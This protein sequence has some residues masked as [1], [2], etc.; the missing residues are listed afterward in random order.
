LA[1]RVFEIAKEL[2]VKSKAVVEKCHAEG[3]P[4]TIIKNHMSTVSAGLEATIREWFAAS[5]DGEEHTAI[6]TGE[7]VDLKQARA[8]PKKAKA[9]SSDGDEGADGD[10]ETGGGTAT[11]TEPPAPSATP[12]A[13]PAP[14]AG[15][16]D[17]PPAASER[18]AP[19]AAAPARAPT[20][21]PAPAATPVGPAVRAEAPAVSDESS[22]ADNAAPKAQQNVPERPKDVT[23]AGPQ[24]EKKAPVRLSGPKVVRVEAPDRIEP[25]RPR[26]TGP[27]DGGMGFGGPGPM[28]A[29]VDD[30]GRSP[31]R[32]GPGGG[33]RRDAGSGGGGERRRGRTDTGVGTSSNAGFSEQDLAEREMRLQ[34]SGGYLK[35]R[36]QQLRRQGGTG[37]RA[38]TPAQKG[39]KVTIAEPF[40]IKDLSA[41]TGV[42]G[43]DIVKKLFMQGV[44]ATIN[45]GIETEKAQ[46][47]MI[48]YDIE[49]EVVEAKSAEQKVSESFAEREM[50]N[51]Q[52]RGPS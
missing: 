19:A 10:A 51:E 29:P 18:A 24:L 31:R 44:M 16:S 25:P 27:R 4:D 7:K 21:A 33:R 28:D 15:L 13:P 38:Q 5:D 35:Q 52:P 3:I 1:K 11:L 37:D 17:S 12:V 14:P 42:K 8:K 49:L 9:K 36:R 26:R 30:S 40:T 6:E 45:S 48:D 46:E 47:I 32:G 43:A 41:A 39:G 2:G 23:P 34:R 20:H 50:V 22:A